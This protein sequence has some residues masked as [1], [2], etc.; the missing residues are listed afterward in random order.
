MTDDIEL[1]EAL[2]RIADLEA[3]I[4]HLTMKLVWKVSLE[5]QIAA[6]RAERLALA[7]DLDRKEDDRV[8]KAGYR[9]A[10]R[11]QRDET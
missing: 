5:K 4:E 11:E 9:A 6:A 2:D 8:R 10:I 3:Q 1:A 7:R